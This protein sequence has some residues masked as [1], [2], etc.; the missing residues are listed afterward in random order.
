M[1]RENALFTFCYFLKFESGQ[2]KKYTIMHRLEYYDIIM[3]CFISKLNA[4]M[5]FCFKIVIAGSHG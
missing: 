4:A 5:F 2:L 3:R 1:T